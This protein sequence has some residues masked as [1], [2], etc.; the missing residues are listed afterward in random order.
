MKLASLPR[1]PLAT[2]P[3]PL[4]DYNETIPQLADRVGFSG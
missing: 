3:P 4:H 1:V 2:L